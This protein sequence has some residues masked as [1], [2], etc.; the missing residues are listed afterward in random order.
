MM[1]RRGFLGTMTAAMLLTGRLGWAADARKIEK[2][3]VQLY[4]VREAMKQDFEGT[5]AKVAAIGYREVEFG[6]ASCRERV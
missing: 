1:D 3:G 5:L 4:T 2:I 6:R